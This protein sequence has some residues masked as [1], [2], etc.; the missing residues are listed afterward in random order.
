LQEVYSNVD[1]YLDFC[2]GFKELQNSNPLK[3]KSC[4]PRE[5]VFLPPPA[6]LKDDLEIVCLPEA[7][8]MGGDCRFK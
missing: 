3:S 5:Y 4:V 1:F 7:G 2:F 6:G 8:L